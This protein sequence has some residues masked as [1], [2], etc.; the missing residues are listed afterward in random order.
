LIF[1]NFFHPVDN[2]FDKSR[3]IRLLGRMKSKEMPLQ[4]GALGQKFP[5]YAQPQRDDTHPRPV[6][7]GSLPQGQPVVYPKLQQMG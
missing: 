3:Q 7:M 6:Q 2:L 1:H 5:T 4:M